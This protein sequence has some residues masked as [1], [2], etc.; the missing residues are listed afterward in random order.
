M[1]ERK[2]MDNYYDST[3]KEIRK[4]ISESNKI[5]ALSMVEEELSMPYIPSE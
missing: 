4:L 3:L 2:N 1:I 5:E